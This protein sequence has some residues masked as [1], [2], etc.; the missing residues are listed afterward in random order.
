MP[1]LILPTIPQSNKILCPISGIE[2]KFKEL[3]PVKF[4][5]IDEKMEHAKLIA[6]KERY[7]CPV[8]M[9]VLTDSIRCYY[10]KTS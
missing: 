3:L 5:S 2:L 10:L 8:S 9:D 6:K 1:Y 4:T 7:I